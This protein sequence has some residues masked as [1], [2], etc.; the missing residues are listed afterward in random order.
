MCRSSQRW[1]IKP[2][3]AQPAQPLPNLCPTSEALGRMALPNLPNP[4]ASLACIGLQLAGPVH[5]LYVRKQVGQVGQVGQRKQR[6]G[7]TLPTLTSGRSGRSGKWRSDAVSEAMPEP[8]RKTE[9]NV[10]RYSPG[11]VHTGHMARNLPLVAGFELW[12]STPL[13]GSVGRFSGVPA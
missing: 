11:S 8:E 9:P 13:S 12:F 3:F 7:I 6:C 2:P 1:R 4:F 10:K 5:S